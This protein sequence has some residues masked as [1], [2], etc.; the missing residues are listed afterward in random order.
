MN[1]TPENPFARGYLAMVSERVLMIIFDDKQFH[2][3]GSIAA[4]ILGYLI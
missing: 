2:K 3:Q 4:L 1:T